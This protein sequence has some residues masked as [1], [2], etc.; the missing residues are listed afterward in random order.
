MIGSDFDTF[1]YENKVKELNDEDFEKD[2][3]FLYDLKG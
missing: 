3:N 1:G 2:K